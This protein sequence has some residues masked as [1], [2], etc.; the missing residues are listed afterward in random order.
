VTL[1]SNRVRG[2]SCSW[3]AMQPVLG[4]FAAALIRLRLWLLQYFL[5]RDCSCNSILQLQQCS[6][7]GSRTR[8]IFS[9]LFPT[10]LLCLQHLSIYIY[11]LYSASFISNFCT[12][13]YYYYIYFS[14]TNSTN[15]HFHFFVFVLVLYSVRPATGNLQDS[16]SLI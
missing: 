8:S 1:Y 10:H 4:L 14:S 9:Y 15:I 11:F 5:S 2:G 3:E 7:M 16:S 12:L 6:G 13:S